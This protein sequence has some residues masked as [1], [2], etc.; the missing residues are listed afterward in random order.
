MEDSVFK[1]ILKY[2][3]HSSILAIRDTR[4]NSIFCFKEVNIEEVEKEINKLNSKNA[5]QNSDIPKRIVKENPDTFSDFLCKSINA[6]FKTSIPNSL[7][8]ADI[9]SLKNKDF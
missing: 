4:E 7:K 2:K 3:N 1:A 9:T 6:T 5:S 8:L